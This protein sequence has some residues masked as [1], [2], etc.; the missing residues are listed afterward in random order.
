MDNNKPISTYTHGMIDF[1]TAG[2]LLAIPRLLGWSEV[3][4]RFMTG[5]ALGT[6]FYSL[7]TRYEWGL[8]KAVPMQGHLV[9]DGMNALTFMALPL[10]LEDESTAVRAALAGIGAFE[11]AV[12]LMTNPEYTEEELYAEMKQRQETQTVYSV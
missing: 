9:L 8:T 12:T 4:T 6:V 3:V 5:A 10:I 2:A 1:S 7:I 11:M